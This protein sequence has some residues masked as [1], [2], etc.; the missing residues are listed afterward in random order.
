MSPFATAGALAAA[1]DLGLMHKL[2]PGVFTEDKGLDMRSALL[3]GLLGYGVGS[4]G[5]SEAEEHHATSARDLQTA[6]YRTQ[7]MLAQ[8]RAAAAAREHIL[9]EALATSEH[10]R[11][12]QAI[13]QRAKEESER[14][15]RV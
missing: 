10:R 11:Q 13:A 6:L 8:E 7:M 2:A 12:L 14:G 15:K 4:Y 3:A 1:Y 5:K 9:H